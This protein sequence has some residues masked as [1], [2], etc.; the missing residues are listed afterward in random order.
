[1]L[2]GATKRRRPTLKKRGSKSR[3]QKSTRNA[4][5][6]SGAL[7]KSYW[8]GS[9]RRQNDARPQA[10]L[11]SVTAGR[12]DAGANGGFDSM[13]HAQVFQKAGQYGLN[14][15]KSGNQGSGMQN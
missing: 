3:L 14:H 8:V 6:H 11:Y 15:M 7:C 10:M 2:S 1:M 12:G 5:I 4:G 13:Q 9:L